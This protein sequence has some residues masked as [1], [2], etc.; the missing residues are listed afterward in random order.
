M[1]MREH[2]LIITSSLITLRFS[3]QNQL[4][5]ESPGGLNTTEG[6]EGNKGMLRAGESLPWRRAHQLVTQHL[7]IS[8]E[9]IQRITFYRPNRL[10]F[11]SYAYLCI[12]IHMYVCNNNWWTERDHGFESEPGEGQGRVWRKTKEEGNDL[13]TL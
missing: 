13:S 6:T 2:Q 1:T 7:M 11:H 4:M 10:Y 12:Y 9:N 8:P 3:Q 5:E